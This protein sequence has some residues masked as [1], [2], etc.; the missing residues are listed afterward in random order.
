MKTRITEKFKD[1]K[2]ANRKAL[3]PFFMPG[4]QGEQSI[5]D[6]I[7][8]L[9]ESGADLIELGVPFSD[10]M[11]DGPVIQRSAE[12]ALAR[13]VMTD[14]VLAAVKQ[15]RETTQIPL[16]LLVYYNSVFKYG[17]ARFAAACVDAGID[18]LIIPDLP[19]EEQGELTGITK[20]LPLDVITLVAKTSKDR[21]KT[22]LAETEGFIYCVST[23]GV[24][25]ERS[26][27][28][29]GLKDFLSEIMAH[30]DVPRCVGF[31]IASAAQA[32]E[33][34]AYAEGVIVGSALVRRFLDENAEAGYALIRGMRQALDA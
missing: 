22:V 27:V 8:G 33:V 5:A 21:L 12:A 17:G 20:D 9:E 15:A 24:T 2:A 1:L 34:G 28:Y 10:P 19:F 23:T 30:T 26:Q 31:G 25:G 6:T 14:D 32:A 13:G 18:G 16:L 3:I 29:S 7:L 11:A 4:A